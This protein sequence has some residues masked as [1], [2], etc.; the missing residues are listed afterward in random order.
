M[1]TLGDTIGRIAA[2]KA[3]AHAAPGHGSDG[4]VDLR[5]FGSNPGALRA[6]IHI[7]AGLPLGAPLV[8]VL[9][10]CT[11]TAAGYDRGAGWSGLADANGF[12]LL[13]PEQVRSN[14][15]NLCF[16]WFEPG[17]TSLGSGEL[18]SIIHMIDAIIAGHGV[19]PARVFVT[20]L[21]AGGAMAMALLA[22]HPDRFAG[23]G[24]IAGLAYG[25][26]A[27]VPEAFDRMRG[28]GLK[29]GP[30]LAAK[31]TARPKAWPRLSIWQGTTDATVDSANAEA[32]ILQWCAATGLAT[33]PAV[34]ENIGRARRRIWRDKAGQ[35]AIECFTIASMGHGTPIAT[36]G[37]EACGSTAPFMLDVGLSST[38]RMAAFWG[39]APVVAAPALQSPTQPGPASSITGIIEDA[40]RSAG[41]R[42]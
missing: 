8:V 33:P 38:R 34:S 25:I 20:G 30:M 18:A 41:L 23:G 36:T 31:I 16:N 28:H 12:A 35:P 7:P 26:A 3:A 14:N 17:D 22:V 10:G 21:S 39:I 27:N 19:D 5:D 40:L 9:H 29:P 1:R 42:R 24:I 6:Y 2:Q 13:F 37:A 4:M 15:A 11:Q 32:I